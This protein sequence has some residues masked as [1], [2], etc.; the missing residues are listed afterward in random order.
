M[1]VDAKN[2][3]VL[4][5][6][7]VVLIDVPS[8]T[9]RAM[10]S[11]AFKDLM[12][13]ASGGTITTSPDRR[14]LIHYTIQVYNATRVALIAK[15]AAVKQWYVGLQWAHFDTYIWTART[16]DAYIA[17]NVTFLDPF[18]HVKRH[19]NLAARRFNVSHKAEEIVTAFKAI[20]D[21]FGLTPGAIASKKVTH[22]SEDDARLTD[23]ALHGPDSEDDNSNVGGSDSD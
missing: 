20:L 21:E 14:T 11:P 19:Y 23:E 4:Q 22:N 3:R 8:V 1:L 10:T 6:Q 17:V 9:A 2:K 18:D 7:A 12:S 15:L 16:S 5:A 13:Q